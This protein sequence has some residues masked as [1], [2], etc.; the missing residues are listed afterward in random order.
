MLITAHDALVCPKLRYAGTQVPGSSVLKENLG[1]ESSPSVSKSV[2]SVRWLDFSARSDSTANE[3][4]STFHDV[5]EPLSV[6]EASYA[7]AL[8][9]RE[10]C[11]RSSGAA[12]EAASIGESAAPAPCPE[13]SGVVVDG[14]VSAIA[15]A[16]RAAGSSPAAVIVVAGIAEDDA[17]LAAASTRAAAAGDVA[18]SHGSAS[19]AAFNMVGRFFGAIVSMSSISE[20][21]GSDM[22]QS[23]L[24]C[25][26]AVR[27]IDCPD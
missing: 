6:I 10:R 25:A 16:T 15:A 17:A 12:N 20:A 11:A 7:W 26:M 4:E 14:G 19:T 24:Y 9:E 27:V 5:D 18:R 13:T 8:L 23:R 22:M 1:C 2:T 3:L 21:R